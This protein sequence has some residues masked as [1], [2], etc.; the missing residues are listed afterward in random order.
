[1]IP[2][3][4]TTGRVDCP[5]HAKSPLRPVLDRLI[6]EQIHNWIRVDGY[7]LNTTINSCT[8]FMPPASSAS[9]LTL[10]IRTTGLVPLAV[11]LATLATLAAFRRLRPAFDFMLPLTM[12]T[13]PA[14]TLTPLPARSSTTSLA[15]SLGFSVNT[16]RI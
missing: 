3:V 6:A 2:H 9:A 5:T 11:T 8:A 14:F 13:R 10:R 16:S 4:Q 12:Y 1:M 7:S 15:L